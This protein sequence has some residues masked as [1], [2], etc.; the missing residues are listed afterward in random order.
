MRE[1]R[2]DSTQ[3]VVLAIALHAFLFALMFVGLWWNRDAA[4]IAAAGSPISAEMVDTSELSTQMQRA[5][6]RDPEPL[7][8]PE[9]EPA[10]PQVEEEEAAPL[11]QPIPE[12]APQESPVPKQQEAQDFVPEPSPVEQ[13]KVDR[14][15]IAAEQRER[16]QEEKRRQE[17]IDLTRSEER[18]VGKECVRT[19]RSRRSPQH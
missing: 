17:Q 11:P 16:E 1:T 10:P 14:N 12:P 15:A 8:E 7:P 19:C 18:R 13:E 9:P 2:A 5:L 6:A 3:A 4:P